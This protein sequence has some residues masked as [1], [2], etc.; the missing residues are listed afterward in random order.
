MSEELSGQSE[1]LASAIGFFKM[2]SATRAKPES[3]PDE[4]ALPVHA[5]TRAQV[6]RRATAEGGGKAPQA[7]P[8]ALALV[9]APRETD[10]D[11]E[12]F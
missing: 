5:R 9:P 10:S 7:R 3:R 8:R 12:E 4:V 2:E 11:F 1:Q 6:S